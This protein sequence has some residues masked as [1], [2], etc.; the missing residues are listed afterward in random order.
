[1]HHPIVN[2]SGRNRVDANPRGGQFQRQ[3]FYQA[4]DRVLAGDIGS[5]VGE[6]DDSRDGRRSNDGASAS[7]FHGLDAM[8]HGEPYARDVGAQDAFELRCGVRLER[9]Y[10]SLR[11]RIREQNV[12]AAKS[13]HRGL[14]SRSHCRLIGS[15]GNALR[16]TLA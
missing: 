11:A 2:R 5:S 12:D 9:L 10:Q 7:L 8:F 3:P 6:T 14:D 16:Q 1:M 15:V 4:A 13:F